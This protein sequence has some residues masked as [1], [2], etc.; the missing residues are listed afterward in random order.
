MT[1]RK[2]P[3][4]ARTIAL[5]CLLSACGSNAHSQKKI[6]PPDISRPE[7]GANVTRVPGFS[8]I[9]VTATS[10]LAEYPPSGSTRPNGWILTTPDDWRGALLAAQFAARPVDGAILLT[11]RTF[12]TTPSQDVMGRVT[13]R[14]FPRSGATGIQILLFR[15]LGNDVLLALTKLQL[16]IA[17]L[18]AK[19]PDA[20]DLQLVPYRGGFSGHYSGAV[21]IVSEQDPAYALPAGAW[22]AYS[23]DTIAFVTPN[24]IPA[25]TAALLVQR[26]KLLAAKPAIYIIGPPSAVSAK[27]QAK[28][29]QYG[30]VKRVAGPTPIAT[31]IALARYHDPSTGFGWGLTH[32]PVS[33]SLL[34][35]NDWEAGAAAYNLAATGPQA[36]LL[37]TDGPGPLPPAVVAYLHQLS[38]GGPNQGYVVGSTAEISSATLQEFD[39]LLSRRP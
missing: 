14:S 30:A 36:P 2:L 37:L 13:S 10:V 1:F 9:D 32:G 6:L 20:L 23:G 33:V 11:N 39:G 7:Y 15:K 27:V 38:T 8:P 19:T 28:L 31:A 3:P 17:E 16:H 35:E 5:A 25:K 34:N 4:L 24:G 22:S 21:L 29:Q 26:E 18:L 12:L